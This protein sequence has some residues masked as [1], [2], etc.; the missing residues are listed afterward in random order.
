MNSKNYY[1]ILGV[2]KNAT[3]DEIKKKYKTLAL[4]YH[5]DKNDDPHARDIFNKATEAYQVLIDPY[6]RG[7]YDVVL[8][9]R[10]HHMDFPPLFSLLSANFD[11][12]HSNLFRE[13]DIGASMPQLQSNLFNNIQF[14]NKA[15][16]Q[17]YSFMSVSKQDE[18]GNIIRKECETKNGKTTCREYRTGSKKNLELD[19]DKKQKK[20]RIKNDNK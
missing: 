7:R 17:T 1:Q 14:P 10:V 16:Q 19:K 4:K 9:K 15:S 2:H 6:K 13:V 18:H 5:P 20:Y 8:E 3:D 11:R 12:M